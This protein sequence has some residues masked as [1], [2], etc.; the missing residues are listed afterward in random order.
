[1]KRRSGPQPAIISHV[2]CVSVRRTRSNEERFA[3]FERAMQIQRST[4]LMRPRTCGTSGFSS[5][6]LG[7]IS[8]LRM[9]ANWQR[10]PLSTHSS[11]GLK[12]N[13]RGALICNC[14]LPASLCEPIS[15]AE[16]QAALNTMCKT[17]A[18]GPDGLGPSFYAAAWN[19][20]APQ[21]QELL[22]AFCTGTAQLERI[23]RA[24]AHTEENWGLFAG[25]IPANITSEL[26]SQDCIQ[27]PDTPDPSSACTRT[28]RLPQVSRPA[29]PTQPRGPSHSA[30]SAAP[31]R[32]AV[33]AK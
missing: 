30:R 2:L 21:V 9:K 6:Q 29:K 8:S 7:I 33:S 19:Q 5:S 10:S 28:R 24:S 32:E 18:P 22:S 31:S 27:V 11:W 16:A 15:L 4:T 3:L 1:M 17:S 14:T 12:L 26:S 25:C 23:N 13:Q 20:V